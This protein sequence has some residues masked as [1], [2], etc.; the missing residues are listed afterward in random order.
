M[1]LL[2]E[3]LEALK[4]HV[5]TGYPA[6][7]ATLALSGG[8]RLAGQLPLRFLVSGGSTM[9]ELMKAQIGRTLDGRAVAG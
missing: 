3:E 1:D 5:I 4:P 7:L 8:K 6:F 9:T 2:L